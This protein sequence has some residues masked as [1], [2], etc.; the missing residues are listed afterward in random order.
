V[1]PDNNVPFVPNVGIVVGSRATLVIDPGLGLRN[2]Q[3]VLREVAKLSKNTEL[4]VVSTHFHP[5]HATGVAA[6]PASAKYI[7]SQVQQ[8]DL[9]EL[10][11]AMIRQFAARTPMMGQLLQGATLRKADISFDKEY[12]LDLGDVKATLLAMGSTHTRGDTVV[13]VQD[14]KEGVIF[15]GDIVMNRTIV[16]YSQYSSTKAWMDA[17]AQL[18]KLRPAEQDTPPVLVPS[19]GAVGDANLIAYQ[20]GFFQGIEQRVRQLKDQGKSE[21]EI[22]QSVTD[23]FK[24]RYSMWARPE[25]IAPIVA[26]VYQEMR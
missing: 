26:N 17:L 18:E 8:K 2:G 4:Y 12:E 14:E 11:P 10:G 5:E 24:E 22:F 7:V 21:A 6:F 1:I 25:R 19:H 13:W 16:A 3:T 15:A 20:R 23:E 9:E